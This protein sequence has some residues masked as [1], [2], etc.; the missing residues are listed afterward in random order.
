MRVILVLIFAAALSCR[1]DE[2]ISG[3][4]E[5]SIQIPDR[6]QKVIVDLAQNGKGAWIGS[7]TM[8]GLSVKGAALTDIALK[9]SELTFG[10]KS[11]LNVQRVGPI[12]F[13][14]HLAPNDTLMGDFVEGGN[15]APFTLKKTG[16]AQVE[17][18]P[19]S[20]EVSKEIEG[21][22]K[23]EYEMTGYPRHVTLKLLNH[24]DGASADFVIVGK[25]INNLPVDLV[26]QEGDLLTIDSHETGVS[27][28][29]RW[30]KQSGEIKGTLFQG[31]VETPLVLRLAK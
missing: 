21:E 1:G 15:T 24:P 7:V 8:P 17:V 20:T 22:W 25:K 16:P 30:Q 9:D 19:Q 4:W 2:P 28:E 31:A 23:G 13:K 5:G 27:Y 10:I 12:N 29:G 11:A 14:A 18:P 26:T 6:E 3:R